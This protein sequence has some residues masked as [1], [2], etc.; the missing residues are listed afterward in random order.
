MTRL[1]YSISDKQ[2]SKFISLLTLGVLTALDKNLISIDEA[3]GFIFKPYLAKLLEQMGS[4]EKLIDIINL[5]CELDDVASLYPEDL[6]V[7]IKDL[8]DK[9]LSVISHSEN[10]GRLIDKEINIIDD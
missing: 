3:E 4:E 1:N 6:H 7:Q 8:L 5:G 9:T 10:L 2:T